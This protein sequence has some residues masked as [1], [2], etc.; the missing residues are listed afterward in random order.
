MGCQKRSEQVY[1]Y[2]LV[3]EFF[4]YIIYIYIYINLIK[5][6]YKK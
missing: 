4:N 3:K 6:F 2:I 5:L 1:L